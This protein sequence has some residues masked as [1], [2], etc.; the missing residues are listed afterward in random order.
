[1][2]QY[3][4]QI[5]LME[6]KQETNEGAELMEEAAQIGGGFPLFSLFSDLTPVFSFFSDLTPF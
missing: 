5:E 4:L 2:L 1:M 3:K 6:K